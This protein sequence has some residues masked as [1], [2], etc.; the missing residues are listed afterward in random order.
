MPG[1]IIQ[2][3]IQIHPITSYSPAETLMSNCSSFLCV[4]FTMVLFA[5]NVLRFAI[6]SDHMFLKGFCV[7]VDLQHSLSFYSDCIFGR[8]GEWSGY[9]LRYSNS[10][11]TQYRSSG[12]AT[13]L[14]RENLFVVI[15]HTVPSLPC[16]CYWRKL[17]SMYVLAALSVRILLSSSRYCLIPCGADT[18]TCRL[19]NSTRLL[20]DNVHIYKLVIIEHTFSIRTSDI[21]MHVWYCHDGK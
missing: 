13:R 11:R 6:L 21:H 4:S 8:I 3:Y 20:L 2:I 17:T 15:R 10:L 5:P 7:L 16:H 12:S 19:T 9:L 14:Y 1:V 18:L